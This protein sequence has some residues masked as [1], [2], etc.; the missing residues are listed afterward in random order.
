MC[1]SVQFICFYYKLK[2]LNKCL[3]SGLSVADIEKETGVSHDQLQAM[4]TI[5]HLRDIAPFVDNYLKFAARFSLLPGVLAG[6][7]TDP[8]L[9]FI[10]KTQQ[11]FLWW[12]A[13]IRSPTYFTFV[14]ACLDLGE[15]DVA[16]K[17]CS[18]LVDAA[19]C[20]FV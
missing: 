11:V 1:R 14:E 18:L 19:S 8:K 10:Q 4:C 6:I 12:H 16:R 13:N 17:M 20:R 7:E 2:V 3:F 5:Q 15:G 9:D